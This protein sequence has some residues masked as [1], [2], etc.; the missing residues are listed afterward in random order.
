M[1]VLGG[2]GKLFGAMVGTLVFVW[3]ED[4]ISAINPFHWLTIVGVLLVLVV[5]FAPRGLTGTAE[6]L[7]RRW[8]KARP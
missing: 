4:R 5:L 7:W 6:A 3:F 1:L 8:R 2:T